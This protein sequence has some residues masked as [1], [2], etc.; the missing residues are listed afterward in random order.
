MQPI[1]VTA[2]P[3]EE[4]TKLEQELAAARQQQ[5]NVLAPTWFGKA[6]ASLAEAKRLIER[7]GELGEI[8]QNV[9]RGR[10]E[11]DRAQEM[12][13]ITRTAIP[14]A[15]KGRDMARVA[16]ATI[17]EKDYA[18]AEEQFLDLT[19]EIEDNNL[20]YAQRNQPKV[21]EAYRVLEIRAI[22]ENTLGEVRKRIQQAEAAGA[23]KLAPELL[24]DAQKEL[25][26]V[27]AYITTNP[28]AKEE[29]H[30]KAK[31]ALF[32]AGRLVQLTEQSA[33]IKQ[34]EPIQVALWS[35]GALKA[36]SDKLGAPD[37]RDQPREVQVENIAGAA[38]S[39]VADRNFLA[40]QTKTQ[41]TEMETLKKQQQEELD[42]L[43]QQHAGEVSTLTAKYD[44][45]VGDL[46]KK[47]ASLEGKS[48]EEQGRLERLL[49]DQRAEREKTE[50][51]QR[52]EQER[53]AAEKRA[54]EEKLAAERK[55]NEQ[56]NQVQALFSKEEGETYKQGQQMVLRLRGMSFPV[57]QSL[58]MPDNYALLSKVQQAIR[59]FD[60]PDITIEGHTDSTGALEMNNHLSQQ[61]AEAVREYLLANGVT[62]ADRIAAVGYGPSRP[63]APNTTAE[64]RAENRRIDVI[65]TPKGPT[66]P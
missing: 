35:E 61:R 41:Q 48:R 65:I 57:G 27:D 4:A 33:Q 8:A 32:K 54:A 37:M 16:G 44:G 3:S 22:K 6:E 62:T 47:V 53:L 30:A 60:N 56:Y 50:A 13:K 2:N 15:I 39:V 42:A 49:A 21:V 17:F 63:L 20:S 7:R 31:V 23:R 12:A 51:A 11:L 59:T 25:Q 19:R 10:A 18:N 29:M 43:R 9:S 26:D 66:A 36:V 52:A 55:F 64:G 45:E 40:D 34:M 24:A 46:L 58:I 5:V 28:Y 38:A 1:A 14:E